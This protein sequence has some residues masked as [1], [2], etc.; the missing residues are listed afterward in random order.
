MTIVTQREPER[1]HLEEIEEGIRAA[2]GEETE[3]RFDFVDAIPPSESGKFRYTISE[4][5]NDH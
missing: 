3:V 1:P 4:V 2:M 5:S